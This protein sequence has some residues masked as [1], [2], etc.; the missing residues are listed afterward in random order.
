MMVDMLVLSLYSVKRIIIARLQHGG[1]PMTSK[2]LLQFSLLLIV[3]FT[4]SIYAKER[5]SLGAGV[6]IAYSGVGLN[7]SHISKNDIKYVSAGCYSYS[8]LSGSACGA[9]I[10]WIKTDLFGAKTNKHGFGAYL[11]TVGTEHSLYD[12]KGANGLAIGYN[13]FLRGIDKTGFNFGA[14]FVFSDDSDSGK[15]IAQAGYQF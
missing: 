8:S 12:D 11:G 9:G 1:L 6:G 10:G 14:S 13:Y 2:A 3:F 7:F 5:I 4:S 15:V